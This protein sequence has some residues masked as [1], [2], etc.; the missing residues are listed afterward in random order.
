VTFVAVAPLSDG[1][2]PLKRFGFLPLLPLS[3]KGLSGEYVTIIQHPGGGPKQMT[4]RNSQI[5]TLTEDEAPDLAPR[6][7]HYTTDTEPGSSGAPVLNDQWQVVAIH[8]K[9]V[10]DPDSIPPDGRYVDMDNIVWLANEGVRISAI[11]RMLE[12]ERFSDRDVAAVLERLDRSLGLPALPLSV[13]E[14]Q[15][16]LLFEKEGK[17]LAKDHWTQANLGYD[18]NFLPVELDL[19]TILGAQRAKAA[20]LV[21]SSEV[22]LDYLHFSCVV[23]RER[24][25]PMLTAVNIHGAKLQNVKSSGT[26]RRDIRMD[27][28]LQPGDNLYARK[29]GTDPIVFQRGHLV[30]RVNPCW[31]DTAAEAKLAERHTYHFSNAAPQI[32]RYNNV[33]WGDLEDYVLD[34]TQTLEQRVTV[35]SGPIFKPHDPSYGASRKGG[36]WQIPVTFWKIAVI[37]KPNGKIAAA[38][39][40][41]GQVQFLSALFEARVFT[42]LQPYTLDEIKTRKIQTTIENV[43]KETGLN[44]SILRGF[45]ALDAL[46]STKQTRFIRHNGEIIL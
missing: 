12:S 40:I 33:D 31:G 18:P 36:P 14:G 38:A 27:P 20:T 37:E 8:H 44:F 17:P 19:N 30:R 11:Y 10:P 5:I 15:H 39:F 3:G 34:R 4:V 16:V 2:I 35:F 22:I 1:G 43:E 46:E 21:D 41:V 7:I 25:L 32:A 28:D 45:D 29:E 13:S 6:Y 9:A 23:H 26:W 24:K 42:G